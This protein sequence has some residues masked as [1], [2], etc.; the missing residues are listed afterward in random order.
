VAKAAPVMTLEEAIAIA[1]KAKPIRKKP[2]VDVNKLLNEIIMGI[3]LDPNRI[4]K[5]AEEYYKN[6]AK[7]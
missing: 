7:V 3:Q 1:M 5:Q 4:A 6:R 2:K